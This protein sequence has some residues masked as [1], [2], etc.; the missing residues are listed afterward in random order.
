[1]CGTLCDRFTGDIM[2]CDLVAE[3]EVHC[4]TG[5]RET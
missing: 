3:C 2:L 5:S 4:M 1:M